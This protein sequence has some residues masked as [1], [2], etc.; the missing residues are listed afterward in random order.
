MNLIFRR[1]VAGLLFF[2]CAGSL[3]VLNIFMALAWGVAG[4]FILP[5]SDRT[6]FSKWI[7]EENKKAEEQKRKKKLKISSIKPSKKS[8]PTKLTSEQLEDFYE[9]AQDI[10]EDHEVDESEARQLEY[11]FEENPA[12]DGD[13]RTIL[14]STAILIALLDDVFDAE[15]EFEIFTL[16]TEFCEEYEED[17]ADTRK[18]K[19]M[20]LPDDTPN[21]DVFDLDDGGEYEMVYKDANGKKSHRDIIFR[22]LENKNERQY[23]TAICMKKRAFRT[24]R[25]DRIQSLHSLD[26]GEILID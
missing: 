20:A 8:T 15:E 1:I 19:K 11:W 25:V 5:K 17:Y 7:E 14:I 2:L 6:R 13:H 4:F 3:L 18:T 26:T 10:L 12:G 16:L 23:L 21:L 9:L 22:G 24:F